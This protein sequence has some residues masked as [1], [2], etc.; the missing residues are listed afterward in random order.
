VKRALPFGFS[1]PA[2]I[3]FCLLSMTLLVCQSK[4]ITGVFP[5]ERDW[6]DVLD[7]PDFVSQDFTL[8]NMTDSLSLIK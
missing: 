3:C 7:F 2:N 8:A 1:H 4:V 6:Y 5:A